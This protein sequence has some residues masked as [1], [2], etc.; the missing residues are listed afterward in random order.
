MAS[1]FPEESEQAR[2]DK[3]VFR[4]V[5]GSKPPPLRVT[6]GY[7]AIAA[8]RQVWVLA[9]GKGKE[10][11]FRESLSPNGK[12]PLAR[13]LASRQETRVFSDIQL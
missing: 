3:S 4:K 11:S 5:V 2:A 10:A 6:L 8:A 7:P 9:S 13:V 12:T 1:L